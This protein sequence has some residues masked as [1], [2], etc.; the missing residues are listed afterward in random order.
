MAHAM[1]D[2]ERLRTS[3]NA[4]RPSEGLYIKEISNL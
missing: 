4:A 3:A 2:H 1:D